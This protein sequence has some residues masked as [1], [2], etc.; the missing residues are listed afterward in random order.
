MSLAYP[1]W[2]LQK[3]EVISE[4]GQDLVDIGIFRDIFELPIQVLHHF[5]HFSTLKLK[6]LRCKGIFSQILSFIA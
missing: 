2:W 3:R 5:C 1:C 6:A 4:I